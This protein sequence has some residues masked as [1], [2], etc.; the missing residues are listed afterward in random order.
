LVAIVVLLLFVVA[1]VWVA[2][3][4]VRCMRCYR[5]ESLGRGLRVQVFVGGVVQ[6]D[7]VG[8]LCLGFYRACMT[9]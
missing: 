2:C 5:R 1:C 7:L 9:T 4:W 3:V 8:K 6:G